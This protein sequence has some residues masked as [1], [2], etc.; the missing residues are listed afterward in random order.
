MA[1]GASSVMA[2][3][4]VSKVYGGAVSTIALNGVT[5]DIK[6]GDFASIVGPSGSGKSTLL[7]LLG[8][9]DRPTSGK[10]YIN[11]HDISL[12]DDNQLSM[13]RNKYIGFIFQAYNLIGRLTAIENIEI[14][15]MVRGIPRDKRE[16]L[17][18]Q[19][20]RL[21]G[22][23]GLRNKK[24]TFLSG[25][26]QQR[27]AISRALVAEPKIIL[28]DEPTG[29]LDS[30]NSKVVMDALIKINK[31]AGKT[32]IMVTHNLEL[33]NMTRKIIRIRDGMVEKIENVAW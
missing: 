9:L 6:E 26:E 8:A 2:L 32:V 15:L 11:L 17:A 14:P 12:Y 19:S 29:N 31:E 7:N 18:M 30:I 16:V 3:E 5:F 33:A 1:P 23:E 22:I 24:P 13:I 25:G 10:I 28:A 4:N 27:V 21:I 20:M